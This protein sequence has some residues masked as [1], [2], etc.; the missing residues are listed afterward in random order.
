MGIAGI[1][2]KI[3]PESPESN[4]DSI[5]AKA[6]AIVEEKG[7]KNREYEEEPIAFGLKAIIAFF[8]LSEDIE[9]EK[10]EKAFNSIKEVS[11]TQV[12]D[13]RRLI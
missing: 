4:L 9:P 8:E 2:I 3:M 1:K 10:I 6:K 11:S 12:I 5:K 13:M 7:G